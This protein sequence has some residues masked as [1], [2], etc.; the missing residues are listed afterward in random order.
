[1]ICCSVGHHGNTRASVST[2]GLLDCNEDRGF[3]LTWKEGN[4]A[5]GEGKEHGKNTIISYHDL[6]PF[7]VTSLG[8]SSASGTA[9]WRLPV[10]DCKIIF[11]I[12]CQIT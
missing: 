10:A 1:M 9:Q 11:S 5:L 8:V 3:W 2:S 4:I 7:L 6:S 12:G